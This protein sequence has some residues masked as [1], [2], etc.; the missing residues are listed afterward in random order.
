MNIKFQKR[1]QKVLD[2]FDQASPNINVKYKY[3]LAGFL[4]GEGSCCVSIKNQK[5]SIKID[6]EFNISQHKSGILHLIAFMNLF[7]TG[8]ICFK[9][10]SL[11]T[12]VFKITNRRAL[13][14]KFVPYYKQYI[15]PYACEQKKNNFQLFVTILDLLEQKTHLTPE[16]LA[17]KLLPL[18]YKMNTQKGKSRKWSL[19][20]LQEK[21]L[22]KNF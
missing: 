22:N 4:E 11:N 7:K 19:I 14:E 18:V 21:I 15:W 3:F 6:P 1:Y 13:K 2:K 12:F 16:G 20:Y 10:G 8:N 17:L 9:S 5:D